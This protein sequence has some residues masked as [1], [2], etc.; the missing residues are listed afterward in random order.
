MS[1]DL[2][3]EVDEKSGVVHSVVS[4]PSTHRVCP[5]CKQDKSFS[6]F[7]KDK[8][9]IS[10]ISTTCISCRNK[11][12]YTVADAKAGT[13]TSQWAVRDKYRN[14]MSVNPVPTVGKKD[15]E[16]PE[17]KVLTVLQL[18]IESLDT[19][20]R[21]MLLQMLQAVSAWTRTRPSPEE[22]DDETYE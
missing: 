4:V 22:E 17:Q 10:G 11:G 21:R 8:R 5:G 2:K 15:S 9:T 16:S 19:T 6:A 1:N 12:I 20:E 7:A 14:G 18:V 3:F 13:S